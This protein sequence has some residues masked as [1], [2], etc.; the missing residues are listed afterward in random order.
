MRVWQQHVAARPEVL[1]SKGGDT[2][3]EGLK[4]GLYS[5]RAVAAVINLWVTFCLSG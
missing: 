3:S 1:A 4:L 2:A 5:A